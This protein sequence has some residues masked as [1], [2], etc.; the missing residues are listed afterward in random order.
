MAEIRKRIT[1]DVVLSC[2]HI[3]VFAVPLPRRDERVW[4]PRCDNLRRVNVVKEYYARCTKC[5]FSRFTGGAK[6]IAFRLGKGHYNRTGHP[7]NVGR[8]G[9]KAITIC[10]RDVT[11]S[12]SEKQ[13][14][15]DL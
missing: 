13:L 12:S 8:V 14:D 9:D 5:R 15:M 1:I 6:N 4:C 10:D 2:G 7:V 3:L 11:Q